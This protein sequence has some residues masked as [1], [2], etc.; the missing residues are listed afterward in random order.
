MQ[1]IHTRHQLESKK[2]PELKAIASTLGVQATDKRIKASW[3]E[4]ILSVQPVKVSVPVAEIE[5]VDNDCVVDG[6]AIAS[7]VSDD[8]GTQPYAVWVGDVEI[9]RTNSWA[10]C[11]NYVCWHYKN[12][13]LPQAPAQDDYL[14]H[15]EQNKQPTGMPSVGDTHFIGLFLLRCVSVGNEFA[16]VWD[17][18]DGTRR[19]GKIKM[20][21]NC[22][23]HHTMTF[24]TFATAR[25]AI[26]DLFDS[27]QELVAA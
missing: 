16:T 19:L 18:F 15:D 21:W 2:L 8:N 5:I 14:F 11:F 17:V 9:H 1:P 26:V 3:V 13:T 22:V 4:A 7:I 10:K 23:W 24:T 6:K 20:D 12:G 27:L 25:E